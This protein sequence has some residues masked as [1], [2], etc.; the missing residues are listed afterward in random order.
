M[1]SRQGAFAVEPEMHERNK[2]N[3]N[4]PWNQARKWKP[5][6]KSRQH[7]GPSSDMVFLNRIASFLSS[8][9]KQQVFATSL[10]PELEEATY[11][12]ASSCITNFS[13]FSKRHEEG[14]LDLFSQ[15]Y[16]PLIPVLHLESFM[17]HFA[18]LW[19]EQRLDRPRQDSP[20]VD[21]VLAV[22]I[23]YGRTF[24]QEP[25]RVIDNQDSVFAGVWY[26]RRCQTALIDEWEN[27]SFTTV[28]CYVFIVIYLQNSAFTDMAYI[29]LGTGVRIA[30][31]LGLHLE[32]SHQ[33]SRTKQELQKQIW[34]CLNNLDT[35]LSIELG[36]PSTIQS[37]STIVSLPEDDR[38]VAN[39]LGHQFSLDSD[40]ITWLSFS[41]Q[42]IKLLE[43]A[44]EVNRFCYGEDGESHGLFEGYIFFK[45][46]DMSIEHSANVV[47][48]YMEPLQ[49]WAKGLPQA[50][51]LQ[52]R[53]L[54]VALSVD[55]TLVEVDSK[56]PF[57]LQLQSISLELKYHHLILTFARQYIRFNQAPPSSSP[58]PQADHLSI[59]ALAHALTI[60]DIIH[61][62]FTTSRI[63]NG[64]YDAFH[65]QWQAS[66]TI[67]GFVLAYPESARTA[68]ARKSI[69]LSIE[70]FNIFAISCRCPT[71]A[72]M[73]GTLEN[74]HWKAGDLLIRS[75]NT[76][77]GD[78]FS[79]SV[80]I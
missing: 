17:E 23:Q 78:S 74:L 22:C 52:R 42:K 77:R 38:D 48:K 55:G 12:D 50:L 45:E 62:T 75:S 15:N 18:S 60:T 76:N 57:W 73:A 28:Q 54:G 11:V 24:I 32:P 64:W 65:I 40:E 4:N 34:W 2:T 36:R 20:L 68:A 46:E 10:V 67:M 8:V 3:L 7:Y 59:S 16:H 19:P 33:L 63:L 9:S 26:Y 43:A 66:L 47:T 25:G 58:T 1:S 71:A 37:P 80:R 69:S 27:P 5:W 13:G 79:P 41:T 31:T 29:A 21:I 44:R 49:T 70:I 53:D 72:K 56:A 30:Q 51:R 6:K 35:K 14:F 61:T 39:H